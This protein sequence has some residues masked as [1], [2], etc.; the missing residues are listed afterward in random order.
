M[1]QQG[2]RLPSCLTTQKKFMNEKTT[3][4]GMILALSLFLGSPGGAAEPEA[5]DETEG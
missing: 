2:T 4:M 1:S 5:G 3:V